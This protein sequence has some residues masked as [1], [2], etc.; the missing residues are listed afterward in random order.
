MQFIYDL[1][2]TLQPDLDP[3]LYAASSAEQT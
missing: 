1:S 2:A 3:L